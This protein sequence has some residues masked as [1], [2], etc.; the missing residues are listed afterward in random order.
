M[1]NA[2][3]PVNPFT[4]EESTE[5]TDGQLVADALSGSQT[6]LESL[7]ARHQPWIYNLAFRM[8]MVREDAEDVTQEILVKVITKLA[9]YDP[10]KG[11]FRTWLYRIVT[12]HVVNMKT[13]G[14]EAA[15]TTLD[16][17]YSFVTQVPDQDPDASPET[18]L[19]IS[20]LA[21]GC[22]MGTVLCLERTQR[23]AFILAIAFGVT[24]GMGG[25]ILGLSRAAFRKTL[26]RARA[27]LHEYMNGN[28]SLVNP[29][30]PCRCRKKVRGFIESGAYSS[31]RIF[32]HEPNQPRL[33]ELVG[34]KIERFEAEVYADY[35]RLFREHPFYAPP[36]ATGWLRELLERPDFK[37]I[38]QLDEPRGTTP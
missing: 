17:Y 10:K 22:V 11:A 28:C 24:D 7:V 5:A 13:R 29:E 30:A 27:K 15:I 26:S 8:V 4:P 16:A 33:G 37:E 1:D 9:S 21:I 34:E 12:N 23:L 35:V 32:F 36:G 6:A 31:D 14:Y 18:Q 3:M 38:F 20:D 25:E 2:A 19:I